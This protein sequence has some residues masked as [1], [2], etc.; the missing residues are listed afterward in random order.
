MLVIESEIFG[1]K[2]KS[3][4]KKRRSLYN[5]FYFMAL[6]QSLLSKTF[7]FYSSLFEHFQL[8]FLIIYSLVFFQSYLD[9]NFL[10]KGIF[11]NMDNI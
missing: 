8:L 2:Q 10:K 7:I 6:N 3:D 9:S 4:E 5:L 11:T 1:K